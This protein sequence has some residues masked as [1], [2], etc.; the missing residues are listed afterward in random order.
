MD[1]LFSRKYSGKNGK[2]QEYSAYFQKKLGALSKKYPSYIQGPFGYGAMIAF[3]PFDGSLEKV[4]TFLFDCFENG[5]IAFSAGQ[6]PIR[7]RFLIPIGSVSL[8][9]IDSVLAIIEKS[10]CRVGKQK[11]K[12]K[13]RKK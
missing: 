7:I 13:G 6:N 8:S 3:T 11:T 12:K 10:L 4:K 2:I 1:E 5:V 9:D